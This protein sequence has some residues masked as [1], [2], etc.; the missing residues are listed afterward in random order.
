MPSY[1]PIYGHFALKSRPFLTSEGCSGTVMGC[2]KGNATYVFDERWE[3]LSKMTKAEIL[4]QDLQTDHIIR[5]SKWD[6]GIRTL[7]A[8]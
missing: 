4:S 2:H 1:T 6:D 5:R 7:L 8:E 3:K